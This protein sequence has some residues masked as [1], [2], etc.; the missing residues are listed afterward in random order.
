MKQDSLSVLIVDDDA[1]LSSAIRLNLDSAGFAVASVNN[2]TEGI[3]RLSDEPFEVVLC[4]LKMP[5]LDGIAFSKRCSKDYPQ[6][7]VI[8]MTGNGSQDA[9]LAALRAGAYDYLP[10]PFAVEELLFKLKKIEEHRKLEDENLSLRSEVTN[11]YQ[12]GNIIA[13]SDSMKGIFETVKRIGDFST[14]VLISGESGTGKELIARAI[15]HNSPRRGKPFVAI[16]CGA[17]PEALMESELFGHKRGAFTDASRDKPGLFEEASGGT[18]FLDEI[19]E[20]PLHLQVKLLRAL[21]EQQ[22]RRVGD[23]QSIKVDVRVIAATLRDLEQDAAS[24]RFREDLY[25]RLNVVSIHIP[26]LRERPEDIEVLIEHFFKKH[27]KRLGIENKT[28]A[29][30]VRSAMLSYGWKGNVRELENCVERVLVLCTEDVIGLAELPDAVRGERQGAESALSE[31]FSDDNL[32]IKQRTKA[33]EIDLIRKALKRTKSNRT[34]A[35]KMLEI[36]HRALLYKIK[37]Y[38]LT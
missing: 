17:I 8:L 33:L 34:H 20:M 30:E 15:H 4:D 24:G 14:T 31:Q 13:Q 5:E 25:Y 22:I 32:S 21:Q 6:T 35:A 23:E 11:K 12:F 36:S 19:G 2:S 27:G 1:A 28:L 7:R 26:P 18:I 37:D 10:K 16:N 38:D 29:P 9:A 3:R